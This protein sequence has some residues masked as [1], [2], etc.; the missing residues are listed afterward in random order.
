MNPNMRT[1]RDMLAVAATVALA[2]TVS[3]CG[4][5]AETPASSP[6]VPSAT[7]SATTVSSAP[8]VIP[9]VPQPTH[10]SSGLIVDYAQF[11]GWDSIT[12]GIN[13]VH[14]HEREGSREWICDQFF[15]ANGIE[16]PSFK[17]DEQSWRG[18]AIV[19]Y[20]QPRLELAWKLNLDKSEPENATVAKRLL[21][22]L[23]S[24]TDSNAY[25]QLATSFETARGTSLDLPNISRNMS[26]ITRQSAGQWLTQGRNLYVVEY[27]TDDGLGN[28]I[29]PKW[30][31]EWSKVNDYRVYSIVNL[32][33][34][35]DK[36]VW[37]KQPPEVLDQARKNAP[38]GLD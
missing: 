31:L 26:N 7:A 10:S 20:L 24:G 23:T 1:A 37:G 12:P 6:P 2:L 16:S 30:T 25:K 27:A 4:S 22:C 36:I 14:E 38:F 17:G 9:T 35:D 32:T 18:D 33:A 19:A 28:T 8:V 3:A 29:Y 21:E 15:E 11:H 34:G 5:R 13:P